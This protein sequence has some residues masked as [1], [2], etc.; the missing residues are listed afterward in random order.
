[1]QECVQHANGCRAAQ[2]LEFVQRQETGA[3]VPLDRADQQVDPV[4]GLSVG[5]EFRGKG[6]GLSAGAIGRRDSRLLECQRQV[7]RHFGGAVLFVQREPRDRRAVFTQPVTAVAEQRRLAESPGSLQQG[8][9]AVHR[10][11][12]LF[13]FRAVDVAGDEVGD[14]HLVGKEPGCGGAGDARAGVVWGGLRG[15]LFP[16]GRNLLSGLHWY[17]LH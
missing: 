4:T 13:Q 10:C 3:A 17:F 11:A 16:V 2:P 7:S 1:M 8:Q 12:A 5:F 14:L 9:P 6:A 15:C